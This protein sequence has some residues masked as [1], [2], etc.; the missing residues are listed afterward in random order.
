MMMH[1]TK[2]KGPWRKRLWI[3]FIVLVVIGAGI[4]WYVATE[5]FSDTKDREAAHTVSAIDFIRE[6]VKDDSAAN[7]KYREQIIV[8][9]GRISELE[10]PDTSTVNI[11]FVDTT[12]GAYAIFAFQEQ[13][14]NEAK[15]LNVGDSVSVKGSCSGVA[16]S[17][18]LEV[19]YISFKRSTLN[20]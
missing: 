14:V 10:A 3:L 13:H 15:G 6:F 19:P 17:S 4:Y 9:N 1:T 8:V 12:S 18:I 5:K 20:K 11:K 2:T 16:F 7:K